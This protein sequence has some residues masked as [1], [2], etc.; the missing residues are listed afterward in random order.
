MIYGIKKRLNEIPKFN[1]LEAFRTLDRNNTG[2]VDST[3][4]FQFLKNTGDYSATNE[5]LA[6]IIRR[7]D[8]DGDD[9]I[10]YE[11]FK[12]FLPPEFLPS[13]KQMMPEPYETRKP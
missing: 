11:E 2:K 7:I 13:Q 9:Q 1:L 6:A 5:E 12:D 8:L 3:K 4:I 10:S